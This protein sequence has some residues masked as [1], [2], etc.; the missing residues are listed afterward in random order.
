MIYFLLNEDERRIAIGVAEH[1]H[2]RLDQLR[3]AHGKALRVLAVVDGDLSVAAEI[4]ARF[5]YLRVIGDWHRIDTAMTEFIEREGSPWG[6]GL[7]TGTPEYQDRLAELAARSGIPAATLLELTLTEWAEGH[8][9]SGEPEGRR[10]SLEKN[11]AVEDFRF[12]PLT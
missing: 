11:V 2:S 8:G 12:A 3:R 5:S 4:R 1:I 6:G 9:F 10:P 7:T